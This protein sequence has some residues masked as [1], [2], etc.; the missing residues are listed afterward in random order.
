MNVAVR[1]VAARV[2]RT[3]PGDSVTTNP[4]SAEP[5]SSGAAHEN[6]ARWSAPDAC[7]DVTPDG[8]IGPAFRHGVFTK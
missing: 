2:C 3:P 1:A 8:G 5:C 4:V 6:D 7:T